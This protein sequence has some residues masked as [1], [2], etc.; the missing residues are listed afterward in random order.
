MAKR[1]GAT[2]PASKDIF[3]FLQDC[4]DPETGKDL[5]IAELSTETATFV[6]AG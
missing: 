4:K 3:S 6:V 1:L 5:T 2:K